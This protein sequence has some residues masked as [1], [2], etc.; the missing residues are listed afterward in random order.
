VAI[1]LE[2]AT[3]ISAQKLGSDLSFVFCTKLFFNQFL[4]TGLKFQIFRQICEKFS[5]LGNWSDIIKTLESKFV[6]L[7]LE[8][9]NL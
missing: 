6:C 3:L 5:P 9:Q 4:L 8:I 7:R 1:F 2:F